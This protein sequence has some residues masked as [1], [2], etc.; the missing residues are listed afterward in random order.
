MSKSLSQLFG[1][2]GMAAKS[3]PSRR[4]GPLGLSRQRLPTPIWLGKLPLNGEL[5][6]RGTPCPFCRARLST[7]ARLAGLPLA[8]MQSSAI[9]VSALLYSTPPDHCRQSRWCSQPK[10]PKTPQFG[11][12][13]R[14]QLQQRKRAASWCYRSLCS[15]VE[16][17]FYNGWCHS[18]VGCFHCSSRIEFRIS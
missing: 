17:Y 7:L 2:R 18:T 11:A 10:F 5:T 14:S 9:L 16:H 13:W 3:Y 8:F 1:L 15:Y 12:I 6:S 4:G